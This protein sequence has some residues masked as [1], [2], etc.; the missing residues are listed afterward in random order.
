L[1]INSNL[2]QIPPSIFAYSYIC[3]NSI[4][5]YNLSITCE[6]YCPSLNT[7]CDDTETY[8]IYNSDIISNSAPVHN[9]STSTHSAIESSPDYTAGI[10]VGAIA[11][12][13][14][15]AVFVTYIIVPYYKKQQKKVKKQETVGEEKSIEF[16]T[17]SDKPKMFTVTD[18]NTSSNNTTA[19]LI[20]NE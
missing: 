12:A 16:Q 4:T 10:I 5:N 3:S 15:I 17:I 6:N 2:S 20:S 7:T 18:P 19:S 13:V 14:V 9:F 8:C 11:A 1:T